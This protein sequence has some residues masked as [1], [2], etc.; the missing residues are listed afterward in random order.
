MG[1][2]P[3]EELKS[4]VQET[5]SSASRAPIPQSLANS[6]ELARRQL[7]LER[8]AQEESVAELIPVIDSPGELAPEERRSREHNIYEL[9]QSPAKGTSPKRGV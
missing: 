7:L 9:S 6:F 2:L 8:I 1:L 3:W 4:L 5:L